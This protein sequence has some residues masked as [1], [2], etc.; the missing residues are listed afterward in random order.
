MAAEVEL[1]D[2]E[3]DELVAA[4]EFWCVK[5]TLWFCSAYL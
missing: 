1:T 3:I 5:I 2:N 4:G